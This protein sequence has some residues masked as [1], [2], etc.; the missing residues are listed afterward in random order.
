VLK[1]QTVAKKTAKKLLGVT[2]LLHFVVIV[3]IVVPI[4]V[5]VRDDSSGQH[6]AFGIIKLLLLY[7][8]ASVQVSL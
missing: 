7:V 1:L 6:F 3:P 4:V 5:V 8:P 2:F